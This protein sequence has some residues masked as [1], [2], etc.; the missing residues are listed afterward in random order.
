MTAHAAPAGPGAR[1]AHRAAARDRHT[2]RT[3]P[4]QRGDR[5]PV[6]PV[7]PHLYRSYPK[8]GIA[9]HGLQLR[10][11]LACRC[12]KFVIGVRVTAKPPAP[13]HG[14][15]QEYPGAVGE[16]RVV[17]GVR[18]HAGELAYHRDLLGAV[19]STRVGEHLHANVAGRAVDVRQVARGQL[20]DEAGRVLA[21]HRD[22]RN[23]LDRHQGRREISGELVLVRECA[24]RGVHVDHRHCGV[25]PVM[26]R[27]P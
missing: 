5:R 24:R 21:E 12:D 16:R 13:G 2:R 22:V 27:S 18:D 1:R 10:D 25:L 19:E 7:A 26:A 8:L 9:A 11:L 14:L 17:R 15:G 6:V 4:Q 23:P 3:R 20:V